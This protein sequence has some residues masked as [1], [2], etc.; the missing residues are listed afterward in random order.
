MAKETRADLG[1][2]ETRLDII[3]GLITQ[4]M[5]QA[6]VVKHCLEKHTDWQVTDRQLRNYYKAAW[7]RLSVDALG[8]DRRARLALMVNRLDTQ[9]AKADA[10]NDRKNAIYATV[11]QIKLLRLATPQ[12]D[13]DWRKVA[14]DAGVDPDTL[15]EQMVQTFQTVGDNEAE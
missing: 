5:A 6:D 15:F 2:L 13:F 8:I 10:S 1:E 3:S 9:Y 14:Q 12:A 4:G 7:E 11:E